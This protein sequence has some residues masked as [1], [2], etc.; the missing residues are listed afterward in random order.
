MAVEREPQVEREAHR[1]LTAGSDTRFDT[2]DNSV[3]DPSNTRGP[4]SLVQGCNLTW[5]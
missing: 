2:F 5:D 3:E 1:V 4:V